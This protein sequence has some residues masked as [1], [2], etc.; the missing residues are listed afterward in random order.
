MFG[1]VTHDAAGQLTLLAA[2]AKEE[3]TQPEAEAA[4]APRSEEGRQKNSNVG[5]DP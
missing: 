4:E 2:A 5:R 3:G 1:S